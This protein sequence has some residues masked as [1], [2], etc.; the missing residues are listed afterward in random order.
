MAYGFQQNG[1]RGHERFSASVANGT[2]SLFLNFGSTQ[3]F[4]RFCATIRTLG[5]VSRSDE[6]PPSLKVVWF[7]SPGR[8]DA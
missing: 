2:I 5:S 3:L 6:R 4:S 7:G 8:W 1:D